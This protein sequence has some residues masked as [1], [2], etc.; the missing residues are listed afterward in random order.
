M[1]TPTCH[2]VARL[3]G[4]I[5]TQCWEVSHEQIVVLDVVTGETRWELPNASVVAASE[6]T[7]LVFDHTQG[8]LL[9][10]DSSDGLA[11]WSL[12]MPI[13]GYP[14]VMSISD[15]ILVIGEDN[16]SRLRWG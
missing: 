3:R 6:D 11:R 10:I 15:G 13:D 14:Y 12:P 5:A 8:I 2:P 16:L 4:T 1:A 7:L 9:G